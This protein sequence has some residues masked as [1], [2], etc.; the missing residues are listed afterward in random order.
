MSRTCAAVAWPRVSRGMN[1]Y[2]QPRSLL[3]PHQRCRAIAFGTAQQPRPIENR[4]AG[5]VLRDLDGFG[6]ASLGAVFSVL[7]KNIRC[8][9]LCVS[10]MVRLQASRRRRI[11]CRPVARY[12]LG[13]SSVLADPLPP[14]TTVYGVEPGTSS[15]KV[16][17]QR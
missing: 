2:L 6:A 5:A 15:R 17:P 13:Q 1:H 11:A 4:H 10:W 3:Q 12:A 14:P 9:G 8:G 16:L 7:A